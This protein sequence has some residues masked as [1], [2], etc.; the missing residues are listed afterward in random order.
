[1]TRPSSNHPTEL[2]LLIL[3]VLWA[4]SPQRVRDIRNALADEGRDIAHTSVITTLNIMFEKKLLK[5]KKEAN[6]FLFFPA[7][8]KDQ[9]SQNLLSDVVGRV[10]DGS[11]K[12]MMLSLFDCAEIDE[13][14]LKELRRMINKRIRESS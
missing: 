1:M 7:V 14:E 3:K 9:V 5:R 10:F 11:A 4:K 13:G 8:T 2:E 6:A 12:D